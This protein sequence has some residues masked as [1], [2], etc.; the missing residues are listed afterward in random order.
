M[1]AWVCVCVCLW[2][3][4]KK[5]VLRPISCLLFNIYGI[6]SN[7]NIRDS[8]IISAEVCEIM[9]VCERCEEDPNRRMHQ[10]EVLWSDRT[11]IELFGQ[12]GRFSVEELKVEVGP[13]LYPWW[14]ILKC[15]M[16]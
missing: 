3:R 9:K 13:S 1:G 12:N 7:N 8:I 15:I 16:E 10:K 4:V 2:L 5:L 14:N 6:L 11:I